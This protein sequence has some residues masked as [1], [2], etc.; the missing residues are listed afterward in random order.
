M[1]QA[2]AAVEFYFENQGDNLAIT[3]EGVTLA[4][5]ERYTVFADN[6]GEVLAKFERLAVLAPKELARMVWAH[7]HQDS[8]SLIDGVQYVMIYDNGTALAPLH[9]LTIPQLLKLLLYAK[10]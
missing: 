3:A 9:S 10:V 4:L 6:R 8:K 5:F 1:N 2:T 7:K